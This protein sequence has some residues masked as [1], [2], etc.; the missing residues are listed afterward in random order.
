MQEPPTLPAYL[1]EF[2]ER[3]A[4]PKDQEMIRD[5]L[6]LPEEKR[7]RLVMHMLIVCGS[8][9]VKLEKQDSIGNLIKEIG[10]G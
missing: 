1:L 5:F 3:R 8:S 4:S 2:Y 9:I 6:A 10:N 7:W